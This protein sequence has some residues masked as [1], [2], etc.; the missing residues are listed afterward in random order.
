MLL[1]QI[2]WS[3][4][5]SQ[6]F[7]N[8][9][10][11]TS[12]FNLA[13]G[14]NVERYSWQG[15]PNSGEVRQFHPDHD[16]IVLSEFGQV[17]TGSATLYQVWKEEDNVTAEWFT[18]HENLVNSTLAGEGSFTYTD[19]D[20][21]N[22]KSTARLEASTNRTSWTGYP[23]KYHLNLDYMKV[24]FDEGANF[25]CSIII[26]D[27]WTTWT[28]QVRDVL[29]GTTETINNPAPD[30]TVYIT[31]SEDVSV[32]GSAFVAGD[33]LKLTSASFDLTASLNT[34]ILTNFG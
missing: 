8:N 32:N 23:Y 29:A 13:G 14:S 1:F 24:V 18:T 5:S 12:G 2:D 21:V 28:T 33:T 15:M 26:A 16:F 30:K 7:D 4:N 17:F 25:L 34:K 9:I 27:D 20:L 6:N 3:E 22:R 31:F 19:I 11:M 10:I